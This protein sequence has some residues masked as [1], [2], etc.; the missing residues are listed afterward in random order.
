M[1]LVDDDDPELLEELE[2]LGVVGQYRGVEHVGVRDHDL[3]GR[4]DGGAD[5]VWGIAVVRRGVYVQVGGAAQ[6]AEFRH[7]VL[8][9]CLGGEEVQGPGRW[10][11]GQGLERGQD[12]A[13]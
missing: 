8:A 2:P 11:R 13:Q 1:Q 10:I 9:Q 3:T 7:L 12:V 5:G 4:P 6:L